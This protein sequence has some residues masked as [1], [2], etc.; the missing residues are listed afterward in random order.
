MIA[1]SECFSGVVSVGRRV[2]RVAASFAFLFLLSLLGRP[3][4]A[5]AARF[6]HGESRKVRACVLLLPSTG[7]AAL[8]DGLNLNP[9]VFYALDQRTDLRPDYWAFENPIAP[10]TVTQ[11]MV[12]R[13]SAISQTPLTPGA[14]LTKDLAP[15]WE[16]PLR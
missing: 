5:A 6:F 16:V 8:P 2:A 15:Y 11:A 9:F 12:N 1:F 13:W 10:A 4:P 14:P 3:S 7:R